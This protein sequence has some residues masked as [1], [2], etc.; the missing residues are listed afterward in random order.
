MENSS[1]CTAK[2]TLLKK[3]WSHFCEKK[4]KKGGGGINVGP[5]VGLQGTVYRLNHSSS[6]P[7]QGAHSD[8]R[9]SSSSLKGHWA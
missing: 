8:S 5:V 4:K 1:W 6:K 7:T 9:P 3:V 2:Y